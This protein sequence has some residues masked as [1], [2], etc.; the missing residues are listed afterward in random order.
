MKI[1]VV[2]DNYETRE[3]ISITLKKI[4]I[5]ERAGTG[6][7]GLDKLFLNNHSIVILDLELPGISGE[8]VCKQIRKNQDKY[9][10]P[11]IIIL[12]ASTDQSNVIKGLEI[13]ADDYIKKPFDLEELYLRV[14]AISKR[15]KD[16]EEIV[17]YKD[18]S[19]NGK[20]FTC[21]FD[22]TEINL[23]DKEF[24]LLNYFI[25]NHSIILTRATLLYCVWEE[26]FNEV[27][28]RAVDQSIKRL[29]KKIPPLKEYLKTKKGIG[30]IL[31]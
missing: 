8:D 7:E 11:I 1:L 3:L 22:Q 25:K 13:G 30:Y 24:K 19:L 21:R 4:G 23:T 26:N 16:S 20:T 6:E 10:N 18:I 12:T 31:D 27:F 29:R 28:E 5:I 2:E 15:V 9:G 14:N 17:V